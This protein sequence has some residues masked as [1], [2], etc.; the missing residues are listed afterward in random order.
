MH[1]TSNVSVLYLKIRWN[2]FMKT[3]DI[4]QNILRDDVSWYR[5][6]LVKYHS[7]IDILLNLNKLYKY[8]K[9]KKTLWSSCKP[10]NH[11]IEFRKNQI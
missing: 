6:N 8:Q 5:S 2:T 3:Y 10:S 9:E 4:F 11:N 7:I 1:I